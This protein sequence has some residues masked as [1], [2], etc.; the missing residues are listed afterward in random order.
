MWEREEGRDLY[1]ALAEQELRSRL[2]E[3]PAIYA[4]KINP[5][6]STLL[7]HQPGKV[8][9]L[10]NELLEMPQGEILQKR[11]N[12]S[13]V[14]ERMVIQGKPL[15][16]SE[17]EQGNK[18]KD[19][20]EFLNNRDNCSWMIRFLEE[21]GEMLPPLYVGQTLNLAQ[22]AREHLRGELGAGGI[23]HK[24]A[25]GDWSKLVLYYKLAPANVTEGGL[26]V[27]EFV[28]QSL[29]ISSFTK[30]VG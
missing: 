28:T 19:L 16:K 3:L 1:V 23:V 8:F 13:L 25:G 30:R 9:R 5:M 21:L 18:S 17:K 26:E 11:L 22:R 7:P 6:P 15:R 20:L 4:W 24:H 27:L 2:P 12:H 10:V 29:S 14:I